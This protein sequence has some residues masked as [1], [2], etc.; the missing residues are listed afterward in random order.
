[1]RR[2]GLIFLLLCLM[3]AVGC[4]KELCYIH[5]E[6]TLDV[7]VD[8]ASSW[9]TVWQRDYGRDWANQWKQSWELDFHDLEPEPA[10]GIRALAFKQ[11]G[12]VY[13][14]RNLPSEGGRIYLGSDKYSILLYN[15]DTEYIV[16]DE[17]YN[18]AHTRATTRTMT[19]SSFTAMHENERTISEPDMLYGHFIE[20]YQNE[21]SYEAYKMEATLKPLVY[22]YLIRYEFSSG[23]NHIALARG[24]LA[25]MAESVYLHDGSTGEKSATILYDCTVEEWGVEARVR[26]FGVPDYPG[27]HYLR[28]SDETSCYSLNLEVKLTNGVIKTYE[29]DISDQIVDQPRGG[30]IIVSDLNVDDDEAAGGFVTDVEGWGDIIDVPLEL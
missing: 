11:N 2:S 10:T 16:F 27:D 20:N 13:D 6:H 7:K 21:L 29:F 14:E 22:T 9:E 15:N 17:L 5:D 30:V 4:R 18:V 8:I 12:P 26:T 1:M 28:A 19:R 23:Q 3:L 25:G 24:A